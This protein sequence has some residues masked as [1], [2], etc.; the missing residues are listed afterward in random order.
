MALVYGIV[1]LLSVLLVV[2]YILWERNKERKFLLL[3]TCVAIVNTGYFLQAVSGTLAGAM[4]ANRISYFGAAYSMLMMLLIIT[5]VCQLQL[6]NWK[7]NLLIGISTAAFLLAASGTWMG[8]YYENVTIMNVDGMTRLV[9]DYGPLHILYTVYLLSY[10]IVMVSMIISAA[11][12]SKIAS[13]KYA[14]FLLAV[15]LGN[16]GVWAVEQFIDVDF[17]FLSVSYILTEVMLLL[18]YGMLRD[19]GILQPGGALIA[20]QMLAQMNMQ[21]AQIK[22]L[23][24]GM[25]EMFAVFA[26][27]VTT[28]SA[29]ERRILNYYIDGYEIADIPDLA[30]ISIHTV[31]KHNRSIYQKL[32]V[33]SRDELMLYIEFFRCCGRMDELT[34]EN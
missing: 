2:G 12:H 29:A 34:G 26:Q 15:V 18:I 4:L 23:P 33:A 14:V 7:R 8:L 5:D 17:E 20:T 19:Y 16:I 6:Q 1:S 31:K 28:L 22:E 21:Q 30:Y 27:K 10:F 24:S 32:N 9:K 13:A 3:Y 11:R 25:E